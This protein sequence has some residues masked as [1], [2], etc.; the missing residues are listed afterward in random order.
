[1]TP[2]RQKTSFPCWR[3]GLTLVEVLASIV[4]AGTLLTSLLLAYGAHVRQ[5]RQAYHKQ[6]A[7]VVADRFLGNWLRDDGRLPTTQQGDIDWSD[8]QQ[9]G[10]G[11][12]Q[13]P[14]VRMTWSLARQNHDLPAILRVDVWRLEIRDRQ[15]SAQ[16]P[17]ATVEFVARKMEPTNPAPRR[18][19]LQAAAP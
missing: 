15:D 17:L 9:E 6:A 12:G 8:M 18:G 19:G 2:M 4:L 16:P 1:M 10:Q 7:V 13:P 5:I 11:A 14:V 3:K